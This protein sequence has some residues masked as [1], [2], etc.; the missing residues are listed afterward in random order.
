MVHTPVMTTEV[1]R[2][3]LHEQSR[4][5]VDATVG[6]GGHTAAILVASQDVRVLG[7]DRDPQALAEAEKTL[8]PFK[9]RI[10]L[11]RANYTDLDQIGREQADGVLVDLGV[12]SLQI[13]R[14]ERGFSYSKD[15]PLDMRM[16]SEGETAR[17]LLE[18]T[19]EREL[20]RILK[21]L[22]EVKRASRI[23]KEI[24]AAVERDEMATTFDLRQAVEA[25]LRGTAPP[26]LLSKV[27]QAVRIV[28]NDE[29]G[30]LKRFLG[31]LMQ[32]LNKNARIVVISYHSLEDRLVKDF[33]RRESR[34]CVCPPRTPMCTCGH[35]AT[36]EVLTRRVVRPSSQEVKI[37]PRARSARLR[38]ARVLG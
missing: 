20:S 1:V 8:K 36:L 30:N 18:G 5:I 2:Y 37:N 26:A 35:A 28:V 16:S 4:L 11:V 10:R 12:S 34:D 29:L 22:G 14:H 38:A 3:V 33:F 23:T 9:E 21:H 13:D 31:E 6:G 7:I 27:F 32:N 17:T 15:G 19:D 24:R 25:A